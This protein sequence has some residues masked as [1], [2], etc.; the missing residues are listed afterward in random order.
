MSGR[1]GNRLPERR[2][3]MSTS[4]RPA[5]VAA[6]LRFDCPLCGF[7]TWLGLHE[8]QAY[9]KVACP[10][11]KVYKVDNITITVN[12]SSEKGKLEPA[13]KAVLSVSADSTKFIRMLTSLG[14]DKGMAKKV[15]E[16]AVQ[17]GCYTGDDQQFIEYLMSLRKTG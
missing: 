1:L 11:G 5:K 12:Y 4:L 10:C 6:D 13:P 9:G 15:V 17:D 8:L 14:Y 3:K 16:T 7:Q 2:S